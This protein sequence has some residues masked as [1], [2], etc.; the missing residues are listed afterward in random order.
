MSGEGCAVP[1]LEKV[2]RLPTKFPDA[3]QRTLLRIRETW[4][5]S[6]LSCLRS[7][8]WSRGRY[9]HSSA[10][11]WRLSPRSDL[12]P[13]AASC[14]KSTPASP[15]PI[16]LVRL[17][18]SPRGVAGQTAI[19]LSSVLPLGSSALARALDAAP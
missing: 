6:L 18:P 12:P 15:C 13:A 14:R 8:A 7:G 5:R 17:K 11:P 1:E 2:P 16:S 9:G 3:S 4:P 19:D 10:P